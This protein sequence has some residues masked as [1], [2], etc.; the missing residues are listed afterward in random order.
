M[1][2]RARRRRAMRC[3]QTPR[4]WL[5]VGD[6]P[7][8]EHG[9]ALSFE[10]L[11]R[12]LPRR[13]Y[14]CRVVDI[15]RRGNSAPSRM[16]FSRSAQVVGVLCR[17]AA[18]LAACNRRVYIIIAQSRAG[19]LR[20]MVMVWSATLIGC[21]VVVHLRGGNYDG[22]YRQQPR[23]W[24][25]LIC[26]TLRRTRKIIALSERLR[27]MYA[28]DPTLPG[29]VVVVPNG[30]PEALPGKPRVWTPDRRRVVRLLYMSNL[31]QS[32]GYGHVLEAA[33]M[34]RRAPAL[35]FQLVFAG[36]FLPSI[37]D[38]AEDSSADGSPPGG[39]PAEAEREFLARVKAAG[40]D[41]AV[42]YVGPV[43][44]AAKWRLFEA[45]DFLLL[46]T[47]Y[48]HEGQPIS[49]IEAM[50]HGCVVIATDFRAIPDMVVDGVTGALVDY[51]Q[52]EQIARAVRRIAS[53]RERYTAMSNAAV[54]R[55]KER[56]TQERHLDG[57]TAIF[58]SV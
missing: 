12:E 42:R 3:P 57:M 22:F 6:L 23:F 43:N 11:C 1:M 38:V 15:A 18:G 8:P 17:F 5:L 53:D 16:S 41:D 30:P 34:L 54:R 39:S 40:L 29:R 4:R 21:A 46:P 25:F 19:F 56:F 9:S 14:R 55:Y 31:I 28:F 47:N 58:G 27:G 44:G 36:R 52:P 51:G 37:D 13:G 45:S 32:K 50:A 20:D 7:P 48:L 35:P 24:R 2:F 26:A 33:A 49:I 10:M